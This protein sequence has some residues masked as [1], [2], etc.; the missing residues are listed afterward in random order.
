MYKTKEL[1]MIGAILITGIVLA[2]LWLLLPQ[3]SRAQPLPALDP[4]GPGTA[5]QAALR[6]GDGVTW[7]IQCVDCPKYFSGMSD[8]SLRLDG[9][10]HP[11]I[12]YGYDRLYY[13]YYDG[14]AWHWQVVDGTPGVGPSAALALASTAPYTPHISYYDDINGDLKYARWTGSTWVSQTVDS[15]GDVGEYTSLALDGA[16][17]PHISYYD[18]DNRDLK[19]VHWTGSTWVIQTVD[20]EGSVGEYTSLALD[21][22]GNPHISY[23]DRT[24]GDLR[25]AYLTGGTW[26]SQ[27]VDS[28]PSVGAYASLALDATAPYTPH[29]SYYASSN[30]GGTWCD[31]KYATWTGSTWISQTVDST[32]D[33]GEYSSLALDTDGNPHISYYDSTSYRLKY[34]YWTGGTWVKQIADDGGSITVDVGYYTSLALDT[35]DNPHISYLDS[36]GDDLKYAHWT[37]SSWDIQTVDSREDVGQYTSLALDAGSSPHVSYYDTINRDLKYAYRTGSTWVT[38]TVHSEGKVGEYTSLALDGAGNAHTSYYETT[39]DSL[40]YAYQ[41]ASGWHTEIVDGGPSTQDVGK[42]NSLVLDKDGYP[43]ISYYEES[44]YRGYLRYAYQDADG[45]HIDTAESPEGSGR[46][47]GLHTSLA[48]DGDGYPHIS[49]FHNSDKVLKYAHWT[50]ST[51][52]IQTVASGSVGYTSLALDAAGNPHI[53]YYASSLDDLKYAYWTGSTWDIQTVDSAGDVGHYNSLALDRNG[54]PHISYYYAPSVSEGHLKYA[55]WNGSQWH[56]E[57]VDD[58][59]V[60]GRYTSL[61]LDGDG[62]AHISYYDATNRDLKYATAPVVREYLLYLP[63]VVKE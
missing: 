36:T 50:G 22:G 57:T 47:P 4:V 2:A 12:A 8:R 42:Y 43:H 55:R 21:G 3:S 52:D 60:V 33:V 45:W 25:Y 20:S 32:V 26:I 27:T 54:R 14:M 16:G 7:T 44:N 5:S 41:D 46:Y 49:Y 28:A 61:M 35:D 34:A 19:Y 63:L 39:Y 29:I 40:R 53:S 48:L 13:A 59:G 10:G 11:H 62:N 37:G 6:A 31:L 18:S 24:S 38:Q 1:R 9:G 30:W 23:H 56:I 15:A 17:N 51:W 58:A